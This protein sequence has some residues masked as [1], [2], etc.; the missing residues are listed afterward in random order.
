MALR[1]PFAMMFMIIK[2]L[3]RMSGDQVKN[4]VIEIKPLNAPAVGAGPPCNDFSPHCVCK[5]LKTQLYKTVTFRFAIMLL[6]TKRLTS[7]AIK[8]LKGEVLSC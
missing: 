7:F 8:S 3:S 1:T 4:Q 5:L 6:K 2:P